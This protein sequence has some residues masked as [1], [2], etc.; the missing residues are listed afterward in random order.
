MKA[1]LAPR[2]AS[3]EPQMLVDVAQRVRVLMDPPGSVLPGS[4]LPAKGKHHR[5]AACP[6]TS[7]LFWKWNISSHSQGGVIQMKA[8]LMSSALPCIH[9]VHPSNRLLPTHAVKSISRQLWSRTSLPSYTGNLGIA[10]AQ[11]THVHFLRRAV[12]KNTK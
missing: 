8:V 3:G 10:N 5:N 7:I 1:L 12:W 4:G 6:P 2:A 11:S 9:P